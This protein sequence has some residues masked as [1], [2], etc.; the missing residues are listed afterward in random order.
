[1]WTAKKAAKIPPFSGGRPVAKIPPF[2]KGVSDRTGV[3]KRQNL[4]LD[5]YLTNILY[6]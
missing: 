1:V 2:L 4:L 3:L 6:I 5:K